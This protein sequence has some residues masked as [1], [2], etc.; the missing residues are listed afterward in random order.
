MGRRIFHGSD[1][2]IERP[3]F[4]GGKPHNDYGLGFYCTDQLSMAQEWAVD[5]ARNGFANM[6]DIDLTGLSILHLNSEEYSTLSWLAVLLENREFDVPAPLAYEAREYLLENFLPPYRDY[7]IITGYRADDSCFSFAQDFINGTI[8]L[9]QLQ[10]AMHLGRLGS[11]IVIKSERAF[12]RLTFLE[13]KEARA[14]D[15]FGRKQVRD[16]TA[17]RDYLDLARNKRK[18][19]D[20]Y[21]LQ[22]IDEEM[23]PGDPRLR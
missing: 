11:Q 14:A 17:R 4:G 13:A 7:D 23:M 15:W 22:I 12:E 8:S 3:V 10:Q 5:I 18:K 6:Y 2:V 16:Q 9:R 19:E 21:M 20:L 1:H